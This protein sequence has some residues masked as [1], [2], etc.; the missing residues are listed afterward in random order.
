MLDGLESVERDL[1]SKAIGFRLLDGD[2]ASE[3]G[4]FAGSLAAGAVVCD[5]DPLRL[6]RRWKAALSRNLDTA[7]YEVDAHNIVPARVASNKREYAAFTFRPRINGALPEYLRPL[8]PVAKRGANGYA[9]IAWSIGG[10]HDRAWR[11]RAVLGKI[12]YM[13]LEGCRRKFDV[14]A[15]IRHANGQ[16]AAC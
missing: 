6:K 4:R 14:D 7:L 1:A 3:V 2:P 16:S 5:F 12:R 15:Y 10:V 11:E 8:R 13:S 9:G